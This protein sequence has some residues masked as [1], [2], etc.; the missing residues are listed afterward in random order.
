[1]IDP[2]VLQNAADRG[3][4]VHKLIE[5]ETSNIPISDVDI[6]ELVRGFA[7]Q[8]GHFT[9]EKEKVYGYFTSFLKW[10]EGKKRFSRPA[11]FFCDKLMITGEIDN[12]YIDEEGNTVLVDYKTPASESR[13]W[14]LQGTAYEYLCEIA[15]IKIDLIEFV[16]LS[17]KGSKAKSI[18]YEPKRDQF[19][20]AC[21][22]F[23]AFFRD[24]QIETNLD[25]L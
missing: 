17:P 21:I 10:F 14:A 25:Y 6:E 4:V 9:K 2:N 13:T 7:S 22:I 23:E 8:D 12:I 20:A 11:R 1:M 18:F 24:R 16:K 5:W 15:G 19:F 3:T